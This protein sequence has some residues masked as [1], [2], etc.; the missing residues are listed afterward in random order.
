MYPYVYINLEILED[1]EAAN[2]SD[3]KNVR[4]KMNKSRHVG[5]HNKST[6]AAI[7]NMTPYIVLKLQRVVTF[8]CYMASIIFF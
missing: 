6:T 8:I 1:K 5:F 3:V 2:Q 7:F 4:T